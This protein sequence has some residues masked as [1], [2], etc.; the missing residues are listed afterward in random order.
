M[1]VISERI[2]ISMIEPKFEGVTGDCFLG[3]ARYA[4]RS[5]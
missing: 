2:K 4:L 5:P 3:W 1:K